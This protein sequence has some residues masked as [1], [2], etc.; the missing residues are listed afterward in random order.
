MILDRRAAAAVMALGLIVA[1]CGGSSTATSSAAPATAVAA[2]QAPTEAPGTAAPETEEPTP[3]E[4]GESEGTE[5]SLLPGAAADLE[6]LLPDEAGGVSFSKQSFDGASLGLAG[7]GV[8][9]GELGPILEANGKTLADVRAA[10]ASPADATASQT[11]AIIAIQVK[12]LAGDTLVDAMTGGV[13]SSLARKT[14]AGKEVLAAGAGGFGVVV[15]VKDDVLFEI[16]LASDELT[17]AIVA[18]LP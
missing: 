2:T 16:L 7:F 6:A 14:I 17:E 12:G 18:S 4:A 11:A 3:S 8:D 1:A 10:I 15:Y 13:A 5:P 9:A